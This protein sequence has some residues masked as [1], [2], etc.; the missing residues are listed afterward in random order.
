MTGALKA[1]SADGTRGFL[2]Y[3]HLEN[4]Y[5]FRVYDDFF[6]FVDYDIV[7]ND[8]EVVIHDKDAF[9]Y[10]LNDEAVLDHSPSTLGIPE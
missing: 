2:I 3:L 8:L 6:N 7:H 1:V 5:V 10:R 4:K 9:F